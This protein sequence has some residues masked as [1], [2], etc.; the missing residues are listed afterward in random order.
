MDARD[1]AATEE[2][3]ASLN[4]LLFYPTDPSLRFL[5]TP[6]LLYIAAVEGE[7]RTFREL[8]DHLERF[9][10]SPRNRYNHC[11]RA[12]RSVPHDRAANGRG[13]VTGGGGGGGGRVGGDWQVVV[14]N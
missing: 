5:V 1:L 4:G 11:V 3:L 8:F 9:I 12:K 7:G 10:P 2:G 6:A 14:E 13:Q